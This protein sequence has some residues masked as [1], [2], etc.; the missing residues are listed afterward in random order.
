MEAI[1]EK[2]YQLMNIIKSEEERKKI[3]EKIKNKTS[4]FIQRLKF[5]ESEENPDNLRT[6][7]GIGRDVLAFVMFVVFYSLLA[8]SV[9]FFVQ[10]LFRVLFDM[11]FEIPYLDEDIIQKELNRYMRIYFKSFFQYVLYVFYWSSV[12]MIFMGIVIMIIIASLKLA[13]SFKS[14]EEI[15]KIQESKNK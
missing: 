2:A 13:Q 4:E 3:I 8:G 1:K 5:M 7:F 15:K 6:T 14:I 12:L 9:A 10:I 11:E